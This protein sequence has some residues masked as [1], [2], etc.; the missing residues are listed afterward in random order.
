MIPNVMRANQLLP[1]FNDSGNLGK[2]LGVIL[3]IVQVSGG[4]G[5]FPLQLL[6][7]FFQ[8]MSPFLPITHAVNAMRAAM[9]GLYQADFWIEMGT[10]IMF[11]VPLALLGLVLHRPLGVIVPKFIARVEKSKLM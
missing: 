4:G 8:N 10:L 2:A 5:S 11:V 1:P 3:L 7:P 9:F 6:P